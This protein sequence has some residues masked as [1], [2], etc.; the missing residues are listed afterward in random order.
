MIDFYRFVT[1]W[2]FHTDLPSWAGY[3]K[4]FLNKQE[5][6]FELFFCKK[7]P[8]SRRVEYVMDGSMD[9][10]VSQ[11][12]SQSVR[13]VCMSHQSDRIYYKQAI[14]FLVL[15][16]NGMWEDS[17]PTQFRMAI[18]ILLW[19]RRKYLFPHFLWV[20][21][22]ILVMDEMGLEVCD[23]AW[24]CMQMELDIFIFSDKGNMILLFFT[25]SKFN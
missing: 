20:M 11:S 8:L 14:K 12:V 9:Q 24:A 3:L 6:I 2:E 10:S 17:I 5:C 25:R 21:L 16:V 18:F 4:S 22:R 7:I 15:K 1:S 23:S 13:D 19:K